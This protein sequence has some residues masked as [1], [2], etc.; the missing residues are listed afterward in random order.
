MD[1][2]IEDWYKEPDIHEIA[3]EETARTVK[4]FD[5]QLGT[6]KRIEKKTFIKFYNAI[7]TAGSAVRLLYDYSDEII[8]NDEYE[9]FKD[10]FT[11]AFKTKE[12]LNK[13]TDPLHD[14]MIFWL[15]SISNKSAEFI[16]WIQEFILSQSTITVDEKEYKVKEDAE[17][18]YEILIEEK[19]ERIEKDGFYLL[20]FKK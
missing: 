3:I 5:K 6:K 8:T 18:L 2:D 17:T 10:E 15:A 4:D 13:V 7:Y 19:I 14:F 11:D 9:D 12:N 16:W 20:K 1:Y